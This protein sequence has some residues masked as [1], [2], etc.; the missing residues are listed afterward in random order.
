[1]AASRMRVRGIAIVSAA[2]ACQA[3]AVTTGARSLSLCLSR[4]V[5]TPTAMAPHAS[6]RRAREPRKTAPSIRNRPD[7]SES[8]RMHS[9]PR[10]A[11]TLLAA[12]AALVFAAGAL[13]STG[14]EGAGTT[15]TTTPDNGGTIAAEPPAVESSGGVAGPAVKA[16]ARAAQ[17]AA[18]EQ[19]P[20]VETTPTETTP[21]DEGTGT[22]PD[23][24]PTAP[25]TTQ[26]PA[27]T[28][29]SSGG[30]G[31]SG[32]LPTTGLELGGLTAIGLGLLLAGLALRRRPTI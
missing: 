3:S 24:A 9:N 10:R 19:P 31:S 13:A 14:T 11:I 26:T 27:G 32:G 12:L 21:G 4:G 20:E 5:A 1:M 22:V 16:A 23:T 6:D 30:G 29:S 25:E 17:N 15:A 2:G 28:G 8:A 7:T 18:Q